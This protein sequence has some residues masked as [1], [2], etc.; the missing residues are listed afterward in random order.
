MASAA[1]LAP[2]T[3]ASPTPP[4]RGGDDGAAPRL[5]S[6][7]HIREPLP[8]AP[9]PPRRIAHPGGRIETNKDE[10][11][12]R[13]LEKRRARGELLTDAQLALLARFHSPAAAALASEV[14]ASV[15][16]MTAEQRAAAAAVATADESRKRKAG[17]AGAPQPHRGGGKKARPA[18]P[19]SLLS[20]EQR[21][22]MSLEDLTTAKRAAGG[23]RGGKRWK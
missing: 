13:F 15:A 1:A 2:A 4:L 11:V 6:L 9:A 10:A 14:R 8:P 17:D 22:G 19:A 3:S 5:I 21:M 18:A 23:G 20:V 16:G 7:R 12:A